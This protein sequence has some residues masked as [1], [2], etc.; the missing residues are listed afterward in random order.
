MEQAEH[1]VVERQ[2]CV[3]CGIH[4]RQCIQTIHN[5]VV[6]CSIGTHHVADLSHPQSLQ[7][8]QDGSG[9]SAVQAG[10][11]KLKETLEPGVGKEHMSMHGRCL[12]FPLV[13]LW[14]WG[15]ASF[16]LGW[17][18]NTLSGEICFSLLGG[19]RSD[20]NSLFTLTSGIWPSL[21]WG[22]R[23]GYIPTSLSG[24]TPAVQL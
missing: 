23:I 9:G 10:T 21:F 5:A 19:R 6:H 24:A 7:L 16:P 20:D 17:L 14:L 11:R 22:R 2:V 15:A 1:L 8:R 3:L 18:R 13:H 4:L 12:A